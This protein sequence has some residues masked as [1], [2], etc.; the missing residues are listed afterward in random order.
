MLDRIAARCLLLYVFGHN[1]QT[2]R[3]DL[4]DGNVFDTVAGFN[5]G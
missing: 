2:N 5:N 1:P 4:G 3:S